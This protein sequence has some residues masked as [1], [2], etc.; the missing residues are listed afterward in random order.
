MGS[1]YVS[2]PSTAFDNSL[3][4]DTASRH[5]RV[6]DSHPAPHELTKLLS[7]DE[8]PQKPDKICPSTQAISPSE[9]VLLPLLIGYFWLRG[10]EVRLDFVALANVSVAAG[11]AI[12]QLLA[13]VC[14]LLLDLLP[15][16]ATII[17][18]IVRRVHIVCGSHTRGRVSGCSDLD[19][20][21]STGEVAGL[22]VVLSAALYGGYEVAIRL[23]VA[24]ITDTATLL[25]MTGLSGLFTIPIWIAGSLLLAYSPIDVLYEPLGLPNSPHGWC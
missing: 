17:R 6:T 24:D 11:T 14:L 22:M 15:E 13:S 25:I 8:S 7:S 19:A 4:A 2:R 23:T 10:E 9:V 5:E 20:I 21:A 16:R 12:F 1:T 3:R 18:Q